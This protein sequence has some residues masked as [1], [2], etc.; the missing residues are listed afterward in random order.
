MI[1][2]STAGVRAASGPQEESAPVEQ[3]DGEPVFDL[4]GAHPGRSSWRRRRNL[5][6]VRADAEQAAVLSVSG[7]TPSDDATTVLSAADV[8]LRDTDVRLDGR[9]VNASTDTSSDAT[10]D[11][12]GDESSAAPK[13]ERGRQDEDN[14]N[15]ERT[16]HDAHGRTGSTGSA[17]AGTG[18]STPGA[19]GPNG[20]EPASEGSFSAGSSGGATAAAADATQDETA[21]GARQ[22]GEYEVSP[23]LRESALF[24]GSEA[25][26]ERSKAFAGPGDDV[27][28]QREEAERSRSG[29]TGEVPAD[30]TPEEGDPDLGGG[31]SSDDLQGLS[32][33]EAKRR[34]PEGRRA[35]RGG[36]ATG[37]EGGDGSPGEG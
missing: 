26:I 28:H 2:G 20:V 31:T 14:A 23:T 27:Y 3:A 4:R 36:D 29:E 10:P 37:S 7:P 33:Q 25:G 11:A 12:R 21:V 13:D 17:G 8:P 9:P 35:P 16:E 19:S 34:D 24:S 1:P 22:T 5:R 30:A 6:R 18:T 32:P 15:D